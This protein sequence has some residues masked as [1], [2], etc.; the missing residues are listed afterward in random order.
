M[1][2]GAL[3]ALMLAGPAPGPPALHASPTRFQ[4]PDIEFF[5]QHG[6]PHCARARTFLATL[7]QELPPLVVVERDVARDGDA[8]RRLER[9]A[10]SHRVEPVGVP[11]F[12][13]RGVLLIGFDDTATTG[14]YSA[15]T[16]QPM[17]WT[18]AWCWVWSR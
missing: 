11:A 15:G 9:I 3:L 7:R 10:A 13:V 6:C 5:V 14:R 8:R 17:S 2:R 1:T 12:Y 18:T 4:Q 16:R